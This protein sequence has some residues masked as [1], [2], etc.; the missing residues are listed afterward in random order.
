[1]FRRRRPFT[2]LLPV[3]L[4]SALTA[5]DCEEVDSGHAPDT[6]TYVRTAVRVE[7]EG[8]CPE[9]IASPAN[10]SVLR[11]GRTVL[12]VEA[13]RLNV[14]AFD[15]VAADGRWEGFASEIL[16]NGFTVTVLYIGQ[17][18]R[19]SMDRWTFTG[20]LIID[21]VA[22][23]GQLVCRESYDVTITQTTG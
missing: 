19:D 8:N 11:S 21:H 4:G 1:M 10:I 18:V 12:S 17:W 14:R 20:D 5:S 13:A 16:P 3:L 22:P 6:G 2:L 9:P 7:V 15:E 23:S